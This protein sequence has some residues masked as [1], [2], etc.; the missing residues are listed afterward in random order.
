MASPKH[1][2]KP[3]ARSRA[4]LKKVPDSLK[5]Q[6]GGLKHI[7]TDE[8]LVTGIHDSLDLFFKNLA[9]PGLKV[10]PADLD[11]VIYAVELIRGQTAALAAQACVLNARIDR[12]RTKEEEEEEPLSESERKELGALDKKLEEITKATKEGEQYVAELEAQIE[13]GRQRLLEGPLAISAESTLARR[14]RSVGLAATAAT[15]AEEAEK[16]PGKTTEAIAQAADSIASSLAS[17]AIDPI[18]AS[19]RPMRVQ[20]KRAEIPS[21]PDTA[22]WLLIRQASQRLSFDSYDSFMDVVLCGQGAGSEDE[23]DLTQSGATTNARRKARDK[24]R[25]PFPDIDSYRF[26]KA[27]TE[28]FMMV[29]CG[30]WD[31]SFPTSPQPPSMS[32]PPS[33]PRQRPHWFH[34]RPSDI[35]YELRRNASALEGGDPKERLG[36][37]AEQLRNFAPERIPTAD[38]KFP[39]LG[40][41][42]KKLQD[43]PI[44]TTPGEDDDAALARC[45]G[46]LMDKLTNPCLLELIWSYWHEEG[47]L[48]Q[49]MNAIG[50]RFQNVRT[51]GDRDP[52]AMMEIDP[53]RP[54]NNFLWGYIQDEQ[55]RLTIV[56]R[57]YE[58][59]HQYGMRLVGKAV[60]DVKGADSRTRFLEAFHNLLHVCA[61]F[62]KED[63]DTTVIADGFSVLNALR[64]V[65]LILSQGAHNQYGDLPWTARQEMLMQQW[66][67]SRPEMREFLPTRI[68]VA[69]PERWMDRVDAMKTLMSWGDASVLHFRELGIFGERIL[70]GARFNDWT[71]VIEPERASN[72]ARFWRPEVQGYIHAYRAVT[73]VDLMERA[74]ATMPSLLLRRRLAVQRAA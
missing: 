20:L 13:L 11:S 59:D 18:G 34:V 15:R 56:R 67:L 72:W 35:L 29:A 21:T 14:V 7:V 73:G 1:R 58:Y 8:D 42:R 69:Y 27:A 62:Y 26:L 52:L 32:H 24:L 17:G 65:H 71:R 55:H 28:I 33:P 22:L 10:N 12:L 70:L 47:M 51:P 2:S 54:L 48:I 50:R 45:Y 74:E 9:E 5:K 68:M 63:D 44:V 16:E 37:L 30:V 36:H 25:L 41:I 60:P 6:L 64:D 43:V 40:L 23:L 57:A 46:L 66:L 3:A 4:E 38:T 53:L 49:T 61:L 39:Y 19:E 31:P